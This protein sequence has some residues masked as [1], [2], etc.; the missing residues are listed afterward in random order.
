MTNQDTPG[1]PEKAQEARKPHLPY[2]GPSDGKRLPYKA[3]KARTKL[4]GR[5]ATHTHSWEQIHF[6]VGKGNK[7][8]PICLGRGLVPYNRTFGATAG[9]WAGSLVLGVGRFCERCEG[10]GTLSERITSNTVAR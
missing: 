9:V 8:C 10:K 3:R 2:T 6:P 7:R 1:A 4:T 5:G